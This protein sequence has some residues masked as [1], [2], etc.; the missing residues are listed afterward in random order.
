MTTTTSPK[1]FLKWAG[2]KKQ[3]LMD[4]RA[5]SPKELIDNNI[6]TY[7]EPFLGGGAV[8]FDILDK[9]SIKNV[10]VNDINRDLIFTYQIVR[11]RCSAL[12]S[13]LTLYEQEYLI[14]NEDERKEYYYSK[15]KLYNSVKLTCSNVYSSH[16][17]EIVLLASLLI[18]LNRTCFNGLYRL[19]KRGEFNVPLGNYKNP[20]ICDVDNLNNVSKAIQNVEFFNIS[21]SELE[22]DSSQNT[23]I[24]I[25]P[26]YRA[27]PNTPSF[28][29]YFNSEFG[30][31]EQIKLAKWISKNSSSKVFVLISNSDPHNTDENDNFFAVNYAH[32]SPITNIQKVFAKRNINSNSKKRGQITELLIKNYN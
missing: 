31:D 1:P 10:K 24:Y 2:G 28:T 16:D 19:N 20:K 18:F 15:R 27:L 14:L 17:E 8:L 7:I 25:D 12:V 26:P 9:Y 22:I 4:I 30:E 5:N 11:D 23:F 29:S 32:L 21:Y 3:L 6:T 13:L